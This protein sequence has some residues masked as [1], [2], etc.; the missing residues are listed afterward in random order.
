MTT[1]QR[2]FTFICPPFQ[3]NFF[4]FNYSAPYNPEQFIY[5]LMPVVFIDVEAILICQNAS[6]FSR[7]A[8]KVV[9]YC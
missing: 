1:C 8:N 7:V 6:G 3:L 2:R 4:F 9:C 5:G